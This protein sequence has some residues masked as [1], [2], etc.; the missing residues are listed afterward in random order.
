MPDVGSNPLDTATLASARALLNYRPVRQV[1][2]ISENNAAALRDAIRG[3][4]ARWG[5]GLD[6]LA[7][8]RGD[9][10]WDGLTRF[11]FEACDIDR[12]IVVGGSR[13]EQAARA[14]R[15][16]LGTS[17][18]VVT[19][20][21]HLWERTVP[22]P[23]GVRA[24]LPPADFA[25]PGH[26]D[27]WA[28]AA[29]GDTSPALM[30]LSIDD[31]PGENVSE[32]AVAGPPWEMPPERI[33]RGV[34]DCSTTI[35]A[36]FT[37]VSHRQ[38]EGILNFAAVF[39]IVT[40]PNDMDDV[41][42]FW[43]LRA[44][45]E[46]YRIP[47]V[48]WPMWVDARVAEGLRPWVSALLKEKAST[49]PDVLFC[50]VP[51]DGR[52]RV[53]E[54]ATALG[55][56]KYAGDRLH[57]FL[58][59]RA[60]SGPPTYAITFPVLPRSEHVTGGTTA[61]YP[62]VLGNSLRLRIQ[63]P[64]LATNRGAMAMDLVDFPPLVMPQRRTLAK[65][66]HSNARSTP[67]GLTWVADFWPSDLDLTLPTDHEVVTGVLRDAGLTATTSD[68][69]DA[70]RRTLALV[71]GLAGVSVFADPV[72]LR[73][74]GVL[75]GADRAP[76]SGRPVG[77]ERETFSLAEL[78]S[79]VW[80]GEER[81]GKSDTAPA[82]DALVR[83][84]VILP[85]FRVGCP[86]CGTREWRIVDEVASSMTCRG[87]RHE[88][89]LSL[90]SDRYRELEPTWEYRANQLVV[91]PVSQGVLPALL[92]L[93]LLA[94][95]ARYRFRH[96]LGQVVP[97]FGERDV[98]VTIDRDVAVLEVK[99]PDALSE[100]EVEATIK[101]ARAIR[102]SAIFV[103]QAASWNAD[104][105]ALLERVRDAAAEPRVAVDSLTRSDL[106]VA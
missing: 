95:R 71:G 23:I 48:P 1:Y 33:V 47:V 89:V 30:H 63:P 92:A 84:R 91:W 72:S 62:I 104:S 86:N 65:L 83:A 94:R 102:G 16:D 76:G 27:M 15:L 77:D 81:K 54:M 17:A 75:C 8:E 106:L 38:G 7:L 37:G 97:G 24:P 39:S 78:A 4:T 13:E 22:R 51:A 28:L 105:L 19:V 52:D 68:W 10:C 6:L 74:M 26:A 21:G 56:T 98:I 64:D 49:E 35:D 20:R 14:A 67:A 12:A 70:A 25:A 34:L 43:N 58:P 50:N 100:E 101:L 29:W 9:G 55:L 3:A 32:L 5:G 79:R 59:R 80:R 87:C 41:V 31:L 46:P 90:A 40:D 44:V 53:Q 18:E 57:G 93:R 96:A 85:G 60:R 88:I 11:C 82:L 73:I 103:T 66:V 42:L 61:D 69:G 2:S 99:A 36:S 45:L